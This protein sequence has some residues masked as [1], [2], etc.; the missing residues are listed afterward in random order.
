[1]I[2]NPKEWFNQEDPVHTVTALYDFASTTNEELSI[3]AGQKLWLAPSSIQPKNCPGWW[4]ATDSVNVG[5][6]PANYVTIVGQLRKKSNNSEQHKGETCDS[7]T[8]L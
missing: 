5:L 2:D 3:K 6:I 7:T 1:M 8:T 4:R